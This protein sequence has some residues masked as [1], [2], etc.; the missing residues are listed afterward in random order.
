MIDLSCAATRCCRSLHKQHFFVLQKDT[1]REESSVNRKIFISL[2]DL[3]ANLPDLTMLNFFLS[4]I[5]MTRFGTYPVIHMQSTNMVKCSLTCYFDEKHILKLS[6]L[7]SCQY[8]STIPEKNCILSTSQKCT[9]YK[10]HIFK[11]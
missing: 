11:L 7:S 6:P 10:G 4:V 9:F 8:V 2:K 1:S 3:H 5:S